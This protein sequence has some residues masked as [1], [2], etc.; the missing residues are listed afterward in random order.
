MLNL[1]YNKEIS[2]EDINNLI[3]TGAEEYQQLEFKSAGA[4]DFSDPKKKEIGKDISAFANSEGGVIIYG[5]E[6]DNHKASSITFVDGN[7]FTKEWLGQVI[8]AQ[9]QQNL[10]EYSIIP[11]R[12]NSKIEQSVYVIQ[13]PPSTNSP[14]MSKDNKFYIR[15]GVE[16]KAM[17]E[18]EVRKSYN[19]TYKASIEINRIIIKSGGSTGQLERGGR[20]D[21]RIN[22]LIRNI[23]NT[24]VEKFKCQ[25]SIPNEVNG[26]F[27]SDEVEFFKKSKEAKDGKIIFKFLHDGYLYPEDEVQSPY[28]TIH[29]TNNNKHLL[30]ENDVKIKLFYSGGSTESSINLLE[31][32]EEVDMETAKILKR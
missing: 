29:A 22:V 10:S 6:E 12:F 26:G 21:Y 31:K 4:L 28:V 27:Q 23:G 30:K 32:I 16:V 25:I 13:I 9:I 14:H 5:I 15:R 8:D 3:N 2:E 17:E 20:K 18:F 7:K 1:L 19:K 24:L 11:I